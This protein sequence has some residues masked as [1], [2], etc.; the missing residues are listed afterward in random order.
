MDKETYLKRMAELAD[1]KQKALDYNRIEREKAAK[2][3]IAENC[4]F[5]V[6]EKVKYRGKPGTICAIGARTDGD[7]K[8][9]FRPN[10]KDGTPS[11]RVITIYW[12]NSGL[13][14]A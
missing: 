5:K 3:Y 2:S 14:K 11:Q 1:L 9:D 6:G 12:F 13:E 7:F 8:Y 10:K 4:P